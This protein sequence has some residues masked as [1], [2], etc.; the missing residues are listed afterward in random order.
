M[1]HDRNG[2]T[3]Q[4]ASFVYATAATGQIA[5]IPLPEDFA[6][7][8]NP[9][10]FAQYLL[11]EGVAF[12]DLKYVSFNLTRH[13]A[14]PGPRSSFPLF[15]GSQLPPYPK[16]A[17]ADAQLPLWSD[18]S[19]ASFQSFSSLRNRS[20]QFCMQRVD[21][22]FV[23]AFLYPEES[24]V[25]PAQWAEM[26]SDNVGLAYGLVWRQLDRQKLSPADSMTKKLTVTEGM[27]TATSLTVAASLGV[28]YAGVS[29]EI[30]TTF[31]TSTTISEQTVQEESLTFEGSD[32]YVKVVATWQLA[33]V[34]SVCRMDATG[35][36]IPLTAFSISIKETTKG[37][38]VVS[39]LRAADAYMVS[40]YGVTGVINL[41]NRIDPDPTLFQI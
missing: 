16:P 37:G 18:V 38:E 40:T 41:T 20:R 24:Y 25:Y 13:R 8:Q 30:S 39:E 22:G 11:D 19:Y 36:V 10:Y 7:Y 29:A 32:G 26:N 2:R 4:A 9:G 6:H 14:L 12:N 5:K 17:N 1:S 34:I 35:K 3:P 33:E 31:S 15:A 27:E 28:S 23:N 21:G